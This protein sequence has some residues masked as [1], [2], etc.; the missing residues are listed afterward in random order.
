MDDRVCATELYCGRAGYPEWLMHLADP[1]KVLYCLGDTGLLGKPGLAV[2][3]ARRA[4]PYG[5]TV[6][7]RFAGWAASQGVTIIS[8][9]AIGCDQ[10]AQRAALSSKGK[11]IAVLGCGCDVDYPYNARDLLAILRRTHLVV[12]EAPWGARPTRWSFRRRNRIIAALASAVLVVEAGLGSGTFSTADHALELGRDVL[13]VPG[14]ILSAESRGANR[15]IHQGATSIADI[16]ELSHAL[17][18]AGLINDTSPLSDDPQP[19][20][21]RVERAIAAAPARPDDL[22]RLLDMDVVSLCRRLSLLEL[23]GRIL[24]HTDG[25]YHIVAPD[26]H[27]PRYNAHG[28]TPGRQGAT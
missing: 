18:A 21:S 10:A 13:S 22:A 23:D 16:D 25:R 14:S 24:R 12:S 6:A 9:A 28:D 1:P 5:L 19:D 7:R 15:L 17:A 3:G 11:T 26:T 20:L 2:I 4:T 27:E 8:G